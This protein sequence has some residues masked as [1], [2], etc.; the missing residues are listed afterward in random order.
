MSHLNALNNA[1]TNHDG[2]LLAQNTFFAVGG[3]INIGDD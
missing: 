2:L 1:I 3:N